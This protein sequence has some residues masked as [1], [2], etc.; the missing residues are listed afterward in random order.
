MRDG[1]I[2]A[3]F[4]GQPGDELTAETR[5]GFFRALRERIPALF[6]TKVWAQDP[7]D[8]TNR[9]QMSQGALRPL[10]AT[11]FVNAQRGLDDTTSRETDVLAR[12]LERK[13]QIA[14]CKETPQ[15]WKAVGLE[16]KGLCCNCT[17]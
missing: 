6:G 11:G 12:I 10:V 2:E 16:G 1:E 3:F 8:P 17:G 9:K 15:I 4:E 7:N 13:V 14:L 5:L